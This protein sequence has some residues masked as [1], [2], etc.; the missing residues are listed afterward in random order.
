MKQREMMEQ[1]KKWHT[2]TKRVKSLP[3]DYQT[4][5]GEMQKYLFKL[6][7][8]D[9]EQSMSLFS[10]IVDLLEEGATA[11]KDVLDVT[12]KDVAAF[13]DELVSGLPTYA[14]E[15]MESADR[16]VAKAMKKA[17]EKRN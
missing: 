12:G 3:R 1:K 8:V 9:F 15:A 11:G 6:G 5:Y 13:C 7:P 4:V 16:A 10:G 17:K 14:D 2:H